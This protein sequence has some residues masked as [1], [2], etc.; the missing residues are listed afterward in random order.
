VVRDKGGEEPFRGRRGLWRIILDAIELI[1]FLALCHT[2]T[3]KLQYQPCTTAQSRPCIEG[4]EC[5]SVGWFRNC[6]A[7]CP[8]RGSGDVKVKVW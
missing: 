4:E 5:E 1:S 6:C 2:A 3:L 8:E 7:H